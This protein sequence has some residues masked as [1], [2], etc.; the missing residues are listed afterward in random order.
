MDLFDYHGN[1]NHPG[2]ACNSV[3]KDTRAQL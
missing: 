3:L 1:I 2:Y